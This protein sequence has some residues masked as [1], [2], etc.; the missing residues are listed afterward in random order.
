MEV[1]TMQA[2]DYLDGYAPMVKAKCYV[3]GCYQPTVLGCRH[4]QFGRV[5]SCAGHDPV[6]AAYDAP[7][8]D[9]AAVVSFAVADAPAAAVQACQDDGQGGARVP[10]VPHPSPL[11]PAGQARPILADW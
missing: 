5:V 1:T 7:L 6:R 3:L 9:P 4:R 8:I 2:L 11:A 10:R